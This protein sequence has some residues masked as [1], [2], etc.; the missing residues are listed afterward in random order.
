MAPLLPGIVLIQFRCN[1]AVMMPGL[2]APRVGVDG[3]K[4]K[5]REIH[6]VVRAGRGRS[7]GLAGPIRRVGWT[8]RAA[9]GP[10]GLPDSDQPMAVK[11][12]PTVA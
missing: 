7:G 12:A 6:R 8:A 5:L 10:I 3:F 4:A 9:L 11:D 1:D 2:K